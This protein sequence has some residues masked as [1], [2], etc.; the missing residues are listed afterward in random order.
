[1]S[2]FEQFNK[3]EVYHEQIE[4]LMRKINDLCGEHDIPCLISVVS[5][6]DEENDSCGHGIAITGN[7]RNN[8]IDAL[9]V[10]MSEILSEFPKKDRL[11]KFARATLMAD[12]ISDFV[13]DLCK[14]ENEAE[15]KDEENVPR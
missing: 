3:S 4:P 9:H 10:A 2:K 7:C 13:V 5:K 11:I 15:N 6:W 12:M 8:P 1:M 14:K